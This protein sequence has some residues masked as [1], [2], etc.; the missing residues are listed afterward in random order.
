MK[1][2][3]I[4]YRCALLTCVL[5]LALPLLGGDCGG[6]GSGGMEDVTPPVLDLKPCEPSTTVLLDLGGGEFMGFQDMSG[7]ETPEDCGCVLG[8]GLPDDTGTPGGY[9]VLPPGAD[10]ITLRGYG[11][12]TFVDS[13]EGTISDDNIWLEGLGFGAAVDVGMAANGTAIE[14]SFTFG[15]DPLSVLEAGVTCSEE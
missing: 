14:A 10:L 8:E 3:T 4:V 7:L 9:I 12:L 13:S 15:D 2:R 11:D 6:Q 1:L 5:A